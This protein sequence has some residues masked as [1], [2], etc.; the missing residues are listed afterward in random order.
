MPPE[1]K[2]KLLNGPY[3][4]LARAAEATPYSAEYLGLLSRQGKLAAVKVARDW[5]TTRQ[6]VLWYIKNQTQRTT[7]AK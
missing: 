7:H 3:I 1:I 6:A 4:S 2:T 5:L